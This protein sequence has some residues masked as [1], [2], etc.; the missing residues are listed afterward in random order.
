MVC[1][2]DLP[3]SLIQKHLK[4][5]GSFGIGLEKEWGVKNGVA[6]VI[7]T[8]SKA[9]TRPPVSRLVA[10][11]PSAYGD[12]MSR[13]MSYLAAYSKPFRGRAW[14]NNQVQ[15]KTVRFYD[16]RE[17]RYVPGIPWRGPLFLGWKEYNNIPA[18]NKLHRGLEEQNSLV[19]PPDAIQ[20]LILPFEKDEENVLELHEYLMKLYPRRDAL[21][22][23]TTIMTDN[24]IKEDI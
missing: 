11:A 17:W 3:M 19:I 12:Q 5:Y 15:K 9:K 20:Y 16:E 18:R 24:C 7:Y 21:V 2:C 22:V 10:G 8:H 6:P 1:F 4:Q 14:R 13:D 23:T